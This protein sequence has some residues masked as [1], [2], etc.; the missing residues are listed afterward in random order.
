MRKLYIVNSTGV[1]S[2]TVVANMLASEKIVV[3]GVTWYSKSRVVAALES[4]GDLSINVPHYLA[5]VSQC[6]LV[7]HCFVIDGYI[8]LHSIASYGSLPTTLDRLTDKLGKLESRHEAK[9]AVYKS[10]ID[11]LANEEYSSR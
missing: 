4:V 9:V 5:D 8:R 7:L 1:Q 10:L 11:Q 3:D 2:P 6:V